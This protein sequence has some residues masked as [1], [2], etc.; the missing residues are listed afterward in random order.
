MTNIK[1]TPAEKA[2]CEWEETWP[3]DVREYPERDAFVAGFEAATKQFVEWLKS[4][5]EFGSGSDEDYLWW[6][7]M[8]DHLMEQVE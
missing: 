6:V 8:P 5:D 2:F 4:R 3:E 1:L 7:T